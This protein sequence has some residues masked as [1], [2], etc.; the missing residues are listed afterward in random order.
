MQTKEQNQSERVRNGRAMTE[1]CGV[2]GS[3]VYVR[4]QTVKSWET[5][6]TLLFGL[7]QTAQRH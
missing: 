1:V 5:T 3:G 4:A 6:N 2:V 7:T